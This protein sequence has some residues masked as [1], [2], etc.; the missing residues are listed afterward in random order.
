[1][2]A[3]LAIVDFIVATHW[4]YPGTALLLGA[5]VLTVSVP[6]ER[7]VAAGGTG[8][9]DLTTTSPAA[10]FNSCVGQRV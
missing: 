8:A 4:R 9:V 7:A 10:A 1:V 5:A 2:L 3:L 6:S